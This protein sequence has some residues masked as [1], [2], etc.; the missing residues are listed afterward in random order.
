MEN[1]YWSETRDQAEYWGHRQ[2]MEYID[3]FVPEARQYLITQNNAC[4]GCETQIDWGWWRLVLEY[5]VWVRDHWVSLRYEDWLFRHV[6]CLQTQIAAVKALIALWNTQA[7]HILAG[8]ARWTLT[9][10]HG[11]FLCTRE[12]YCDIAYIEMQ[13][14]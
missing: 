8:R 9:V 11:T 13:E 4:A 2:T 1:S 12:T 14:T 5:E 7:E 10:K 6:K 3:R